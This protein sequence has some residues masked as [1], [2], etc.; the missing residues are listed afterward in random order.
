MKLSEHRASGEP[1]AQASA[2]HEDSKPALYSPKRRGF[3]RATIEDGVRA[4][5]DAMSEEASGTPF[6]GVRATA[7]QRADESLVERLAQLRKKKG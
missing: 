1:D 4:E 7:E 6:F 5:L 2:A 3:M